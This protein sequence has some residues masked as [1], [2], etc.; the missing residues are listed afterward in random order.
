MIFVAFRE[1]HIPLMI[2]ASLIGYQISVYFFFQYYRNRKFEFELNKI[3]L[4]LGLFSL[5][6]LTAFIIRILNNYYIED[7]FFIVLT[8]K[9]IVFFFL[10]AGIVFL[11]TML[12]ERLSEIINATVIRILIILNLISSFLLIFIDLESPL[13]SIILI[14]NSIVLL[15]IY[16]IQIK[17]L[18]KS[19]GQVKSR[20]KKILIGEFLF[21]VSVVFGSEET[22]LP[23][24]LNENV[25]L[26]SAIFIAGIGLL[27]IFL[28]V[29]RFP[30][31]V[32]FGWSSELVRLFII[33]QNNLRGIYF[34][35]FL[36]GEKKE[37]EEDNKDQIHSKGIIGIKTIIGR[38]MSSKKTEIRVI[39]HGDYLIL[40]SHG[41]DSLRFITYALL[42]KRNMKT[43]TYLLD[44]IKEK[45]Q[46]YYKVLLLE[47]DKLQDYNKDLFISFDEFIKSLIK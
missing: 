29:F 42:V 28:G 27:I 22:I 21:G 1:I 4:A 11:L 10:L 34:Y 23:P 16:Y 32:E 20:F 40:L 39:E 41:D 8:G 17:L 25:I 15:Y 19:M 6:I 7:W 9:L 18:K 46:N 38:I 36:E 47:L 31:F 24:F 45:F 26:I 33:D 2:I 12:G 37:L 5:F 35:D 30:I 44:I 13:I 43:F 3:F 14:P